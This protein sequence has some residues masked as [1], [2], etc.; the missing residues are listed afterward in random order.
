MG[1]H[2][3]L[4]GKHDCMPT[5]MVS[6]CVRQT[7]L[8][9]DISVECTAYQHNI[10]IQ[11]ACTMSVGACIDYNIIT[12][13]CVCVCVCHS[14]CVTVCVYTCVCCVLAGVHPKPTDPAQKALF[15]CKAEVWHC[16]S[17]LTDT[18]SN[19]TSSRLNRNVQDKIE[20]DK[21][22]RLWWPKANEKVTFGIL[23][24]ASKA[25]TQVTSLTS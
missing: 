9:I 11:C 21:R 4:L 18:A 5:C 20:I 22:T 16:N 19:G 10:T 8:S 1:N 13:V 14:V 6:V 2:L 7:L 23:D 3:S 12:V 25:A 24:L 17:C 15:L